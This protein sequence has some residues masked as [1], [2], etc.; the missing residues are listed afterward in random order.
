MATNPCSPSTEALFAGRP[1]CDSASWCAASMAD[2]KPLRFVGAGNR[3]RERCVIALCNSQRG[4]VGPERSCGRIVGWPGGSAAPSDRPFVQQL[5]GLFDAPQRELS[6]WS[7]GQPVI[8]RRQSGDAGETRQAQV[9]GVG[10][11]GVETQISLSPDSAHVAAGPTSASTPGHGM[12]CGMRCG[13][14]FAVCDDCRPIQMACQCDLLKT[15][16][17]AKAIS[18]PTS[19]WAPEPPGHRPTEPSVPVKGVATRAIIASVEMW[20]Q[21]VW[22]NE[23][24]C[25]AGGGAECPALTGKLIS[26]RMGELGEPQW[27]VKVDLADA[28]GSIC[29]DDLL[30]VCHVGWDSKAKKSKLAGG[31]GKAPRRT[32][33]CGM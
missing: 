13:G 10:R 15:I 16:V 4:N 14:L 9:H 19:G 7:D 25:E 17:W 21:P 20:F 22:L 31:L 6:S 1:L 33:S 28:F 30:R 5:V 27:H 26:E 8:L 32:Q 2:D 12:V 29:H 24:G 18:S 23:E 11:D 3:C